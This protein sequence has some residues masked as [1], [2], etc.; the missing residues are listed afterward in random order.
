MTP[1]G[2]SNELDVQNG[3]EENTHTYYDKF[4]TT[5]YTKNVFG[6]VG[7]KRFSMYI[8]GIYLRSRV[9]HIRLSKRIMFGRMAMQEPKR[10]GQQATSWGGCL[11]KNLETFGAI[12]RRRKIRKWIA[13]GIV[14][15]DG[16]DL[17]TAVKNVDVWH[18][19][20]E[21]GAETLQIVGRRADLRQPNVWRQRETSGFK[22]GQQNVCQQ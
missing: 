1:A 4:S 12:P 14:A 11:Q 9:V 18:R 15:K 7:Y 13:F 17:M 6:I 3:W 2:T 16:R 8:P 10:G 5:Y 22:G 19:G 20:V 21:K